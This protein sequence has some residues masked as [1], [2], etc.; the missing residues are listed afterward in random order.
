[1]KKLLVLSLV[2]AMGAFASAGILQDIK[3]VESA[4]GTITVVGLVATEAY[5]SLGI[6]IYG[7]GVATG[8]FVKF[9]AAGDAGSIIQYEGHENGVDVAPSYSG[10][11]GNAPVLAGDWF[12]FNWTGGLVFDIFDYNISYDDAVGQ[13]T[14]TAFIPEP[15]TMGLLG[16]GALFLRKRK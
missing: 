13:L 3:L 6:G 4:P 12:S 16:L 8:P 11:A 14:A 15:M 10:V 5:E 2:L 9:D 7:D 1:M